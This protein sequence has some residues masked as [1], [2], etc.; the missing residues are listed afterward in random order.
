MTR[1]DVELTTMTIVDQVEMEPSGT[2][3]E[4]ANYRADRVRLPYC[5]A[6][7]NGGGFAATHHIGPSTQSEISFDYQL[8]AA[9]P[10][11][12]CVTI[13]DVPRRGI[14]PATTRQANARTDQ[15]GTHLQTP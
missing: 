3:K 9:D 10:Q 6:P 4:R 2:P 13:F 11:V 1:P 14:E 8:T 5:R 15:R 7:L 12:A